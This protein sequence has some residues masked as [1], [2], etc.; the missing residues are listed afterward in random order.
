MQKTGGA[1]DAE[2]AGAAR[3]RKKT[4]TEDIYL[5]PLRLPHL[6]I[7]S[8]C[9]SV[10]ASRSADLTREICVP[11]PRCIPEQRMQMKT[12]RDQDAQRG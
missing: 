7:I 12:P 9:S 2:V 6:I 1:G 5:F 3:S 4:R 8:V 10:Q 11:I